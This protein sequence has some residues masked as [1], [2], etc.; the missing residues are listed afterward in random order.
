MKTLKFALIG[1]SLALTATVAAAGQVGV[2][3][4]Y[5]DGTALNDAAVAEL[6][7]DV[8]RE[9]LIFAA[10]GELSPRLRQP[11]QFV[12]LDCDQSV[13]TLAERRNAVSALFT[14]GEAI[15]VFEGD[16][17]DFQ[18][19]GDEDEVRERQYIL[20]LG[21][22][23]NRDTDGREVALSTLDEKASQLDGHWTNE[24]YLNVQDAMGIPTPDEVV[25]I[26]YENAEVAESFRNSNSDILR[27]VGAF[28]DAH[29]TAFTYLVGTAV[30]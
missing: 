5:E 29:L 9:G 27:D 13:L 16:L 20:K 15:A 25:V 28:N 11:G 30:R 21:Y 1:T 2:V 3:G 7:C 22:Y 19:P 18:A 24:A 17:T 6:G 23:N 14:D 4:L 12:V 8:Q 10:Q 26:H